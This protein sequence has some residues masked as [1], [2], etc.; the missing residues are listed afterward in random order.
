MGMKP[1]EVGAVAGAIS[2]EGSTSD[3]GTLLVPAS[4]TPNVIS[5]PIPAGTNKLYRLRTFFTAVD[6]NAFILTGMYEAIILRLDDGNLFL[7][8]SGVVIPNVS[9]V[10]DPTLD[11]SAIVY[12]SVSQPTDM[13]HFWRWVL[14]PAL[15][16]P[17]AVTSSK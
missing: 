10:G 2:F 1:S 5:V 7:G 14:S 12:Q 8:D 9:P 17:F 4:T 15:A 16:I 3:E 6:A 13:F 11:G